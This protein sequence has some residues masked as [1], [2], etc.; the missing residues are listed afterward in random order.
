MK[1]SILIKTKELCIP[2]IQVWNMIKAPMGYSLFII[3]ISYGLWHA[4]SELWELQLQWLLLSLA[5]IFVMFIF[6]L[7]QVTIFLKAHNKSPHWFYPALFNARRGFFN[8]VFP[9][10]TGT[11]LLLHNLMRH[12]AVSWQNFLYFFFIASLVSIYISIIALIWLIFPW[13]YSAIMLIASFCVSLYIPQLLAVRYASCIPTLI[14]IALG[15]YICTVTAFYCLLRGLG[16]ELS[17]IEVSHFAVVLNALAQ[18]SITPGNIGV[19]EV[20]IGVI[21]PYVTLPISVGIIA[22]SLLLILR[23]TVY[24]ALWAIF[25]WAAKR[26]DNNNASSA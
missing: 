18:V 15:L 13:G 8:T 23:L 4:P 21:S 3:A 25:E 24:G 19:R 16:Y 17:L 9:G 26:G 11:I 12:Y 7:W 20:V 5:V 14:L 22:S 6:Q 10:R 2:F 1:N